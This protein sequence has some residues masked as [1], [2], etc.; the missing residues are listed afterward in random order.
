MLIWMVVHGD[1]YETCMRL[2]I[3]FS[4]GL[5]LPSVLSH[6]K[7]SCISLVVISQKLKTIS[8]LTATKIKVGTTSC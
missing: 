8:C 2:E 5:N 7:E 3:A 4:R 6:M 1:L